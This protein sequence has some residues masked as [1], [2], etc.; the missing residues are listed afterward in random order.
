MDRP[1]QHGSSTNPRTRRGRLRLLAA[2][3]VAAM[4]LTAGLATPLNPAPHEAEAADGGKKTLTVA[5][6]QSVD[7]LS[8]FLAQTLVSTSIHRLMYDFLTNY[9]AKDNS[10][11]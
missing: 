7:S 11:V 10:T 5:V 8:P 9:D 4:S 2:S 6:A 1:E 3:G